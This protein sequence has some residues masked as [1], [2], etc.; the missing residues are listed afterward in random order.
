MED[1]S[2]ENLKLVTIN[3]VIVHVGWRESNYLI[4]LAYEFHIEGNTTLLTTTQ[5]CSWIDILI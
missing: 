3:N 1:S 5:A 4:S 2:F